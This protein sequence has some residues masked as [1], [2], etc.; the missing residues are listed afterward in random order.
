MSFEVKGGVKAGR[1]FVE[2]L[3]IIHLAVSL[4]GVESLVSH[5]ASMTHTSMFCCASHYCV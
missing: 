5:P 1:K 3:R 2:S 4:G